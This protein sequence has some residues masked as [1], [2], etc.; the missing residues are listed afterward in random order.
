MLLG[1]II[2]LAENNIIKY[3]RNWSVGKDQFFFYAGNDIFKI[4]KPEYG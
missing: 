3:K 2:R 4:S 1:I